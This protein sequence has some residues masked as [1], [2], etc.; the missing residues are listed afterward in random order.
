MPTQDLYQTYDFGKGLVR[1][2]TLPFCREK[3]SN[4]SV[5]KVHCNKAL[6]ITAST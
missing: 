2:P 6:L 4:N 3:T 5:P 1:E